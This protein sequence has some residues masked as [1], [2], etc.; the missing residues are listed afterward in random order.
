M[1]RSGQVRIRLLSPEMLG[2]RFQYAFLSFSDYAEVRPD[3]GE[4]VFP[5]PEEYVRTVWEALA[6]IVEGLSWPEP[7]KEGKCPRPTVSAG[8]WSIDCSRLDRGPSLYQLGSKSD[9]AILQGAGLTACAYVTRACKATVAWTHAA[10]SYALEVIRRGGPIGGGASLEV[11][12]LARASLF[13]RI[14]SVRGPSEAK[15]ARIDADTLGTILL[16]GALSYLGS[17]RVDSGRQASELEFYVLPDYPSRAYRV[18]RQIA[19]SGGIRD[20][21]AAKAVR[22]LRELSVSYEQALA[23][24]VASQVYSHAAIARRA[25]VEVDEALAA[26]KLYTVQPGRRAQVRAGVPLTNVLLRVYSEETLRSLD[27]FVS[28]ATRVRD[29]E[30]GN[31]ARN[32]AS[33]CVNSLFMQALSGGSGDLYLRDC[34]RALAAL[35][36]YDKAPPQLRRSAAILLGRL[37]WEATRI[38]RSR[39]GSSI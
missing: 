8:E 14:R 25:G 30:A 21:L 4:A 5:S 28:Q 22:L 11:P 9:A 39:R 12:W 29:R 17:W 31:A 15:G 13:S 23:V 1:D 3:L 38:I 26:G 7:S 19:A 6:A 24:S 10:V 20:N 33:E 2:R 37:E 36:G 35:H 32:A 16:G 34:A 18:L 27:I